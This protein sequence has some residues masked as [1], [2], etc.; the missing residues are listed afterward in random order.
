MI[1]AGSILVEWQVRI[2]KAMKYCSTICF[3][4]SSLILKEYITCVLEIGKYSCMFGKRYLGKE[5]W[6]RRVRRT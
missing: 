6:E 4:F 3:H 2:P 1:F 5:R